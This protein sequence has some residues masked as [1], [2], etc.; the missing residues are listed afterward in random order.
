MVHTVGSFEMLKKHRTAGLLLVDVVYKIEWRYRVLCLIEL[1]HGG[2]FPRRDL[3][4][5]EE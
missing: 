1:Y 2:I 4:A 3:A 5:L